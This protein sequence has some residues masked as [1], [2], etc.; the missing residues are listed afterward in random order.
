MLKENVMKNTTPDNANIDISLPAEDAAL[1][2]AALR[3]MKITGSVEHLP[4]I[5]ARVSRV[6]SLFEIDEEAPSDD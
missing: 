2:V 5:L 6:I 1:V 4:A 3:G